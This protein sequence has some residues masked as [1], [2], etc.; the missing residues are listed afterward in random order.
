MALKHTNPTKPRRDRNGRTFWAHAPYNFVPLPERVVPAQ[1]LP[2]LDSYGDGLL[3]G[4]IECELETCSPLYVRGMMTP[5]DYQVFGEKGPDQ[6]TVDEKEKRASFF[7]TEETRIEGHPQPAIPGSTLRGMVRFLIEIAGFGRVRWVGKEPTFTFRAVAASRDDPL[8]EPYR[9][10]IG[11]FGGN[12]RAGFLVQCGENWYVQPAKTP[13]QMGWPG[14][15]AFLKVKERNIRGQDL[16]AYIRLDDPNYRPQIHPVAFDVELRRNQ[17]GTYVAVS[18]LAAVEGSTLRYK[19]Y[20]VCSGNMKESARGKAQRSPRKSHALVLMPDEEAHTLKIRPQAIKD[21]LAGLTPYQKEQLTAWSGDP[22]G[23]PNGCLYHGKPVFFVAEGNEVVYFGHSPNF[24]IPARLHGANR[25]ATPHDFVPDALLN[26]P[27]PDLADAIFGW[28][29]DQNYPQGQHAGRVFFE[30]A[31]F[32]GAQNGVWLQSKPITPHVLSGPK[33]TTFQHYL[34]QDRNAGHDPD[35]KETLAHYGSPPDTTQIRGH[36]LYWHRGTSPEIEATPK[37]REHEKQLT[38]MIPVKPGVCFN[39]TVHFENLRP[40]ELG[41][42][43]W[44]LTLPGEPGKEYRHKLGMGKPLGMGAVKITPRLIL[45]NRQ[46]RQG[47]YGQLFDESKWHLAEQTADAT[48][49][50]EQFER[51][52]LDAIGQPG[53]TRLAEVE[54]IRMLLTML[55]WREGTA[56][57]LKATSYME[58]EAGPGKVNEYKERP[59]LPDPLIVVADVARNTSDK[60]SQK[61]QAEHSTTARTQQTTANSQAGAAGDKTGTVVRWV[62]DRNYGFIKPDDGS[63]ELFVHASDVEG[64]ATLQRGQRVTFRVAQG[65]KVPQARNVRPLA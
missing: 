25:A 8:R 14:N 21:Y 18:Q 51:Y 37:E 64:A 1:D 11:D 60:S 3:T 57:W 29:E 55:E 35:R 58:V 13:R 9:Q 54:R 61:T 44:A 6:L 2:G 20:L 52:V 10:V 22:R 46:G 34:V 26:Y 15:D 4:R 53:T 65:A 50:V 12:V 40:E 56:Q 41:A 23:S 45:S 47:R 24:R 16:P 19:G 49:Y 33:A 63:A 28:V 48:P 31:R 7:S 5:S 62:A 32:I 38:R 42:L 30:D 39:F 36:K 43:L 27:E 59:V 17:R